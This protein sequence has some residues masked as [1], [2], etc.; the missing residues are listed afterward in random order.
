MQARLPVSRWQSSSRCSIAHSFQMQCRSA[1]PFPR[2]MGAPATPI[3]RMQ[4][5]F[6]LE[7]KVQEGHRSH[8]SVIDTSCAADALHGSIQLTVRLEGSL[9]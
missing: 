8:R 2:G 4:L 5:L 3:L 1:V 6:G 7:H 9:L